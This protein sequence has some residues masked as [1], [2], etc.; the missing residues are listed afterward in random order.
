MLLKAGD[1]CYT[2]INMPIYEAKQKEKKKIKNNSHIEKI[3][4]KKLIGK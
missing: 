1:M 2:L 4:F 3:F